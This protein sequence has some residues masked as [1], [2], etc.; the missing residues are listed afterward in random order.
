M[1]HRDLSILLVPSTRFLEW[2]KT[3]IVHISSYLCLCTNFP[4]IFKNLSLLQ[5]A[6]IE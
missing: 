3:A 6:A 4:N 2:D 5:P 1:K